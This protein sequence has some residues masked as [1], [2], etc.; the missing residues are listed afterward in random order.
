[1]ETKED[2]LMKKIF[3]LML[4]A[5]MALSLVACGKPAENDNSA[6]DNNTNTDGDAT[7]TRT[8]SANAGASETC[9][10]TFIVSL[11]LPAIPLPTNPT[12][13]AS[14]RAEKAPLYQPSRRPVCTS[15]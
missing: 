11:S 2:I 4:A 9:M 10:R 15:V 5:M 7:A 3:A 12:T 6:N 14:H 13:C 1:M 8:L